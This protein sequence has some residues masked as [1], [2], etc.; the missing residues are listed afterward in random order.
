VSKIMHTNK[1]KCNL[2]LEMKDDTHF[3]CLKG[4]LCY[5]SPCSLISQNSCNIKSQNL[6]KDFTIN[7][8]K[9][10]TQEVHNFLIS[11]DHI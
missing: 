4:H 3:N 8:K 9:L 7:P 1:K 5:H 10:Y 11:L 6:N 2:I